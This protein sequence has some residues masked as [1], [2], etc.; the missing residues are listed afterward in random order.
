MSRAVFTIAY[1][2]DALRDGAMD[3]RDLAPALL[4]VGK[5]LD[6]ANLVL[7][8]EES[9][10]SVQMKATSKGSFE[11]SFD[12]IQ[13]FGRQV[14]GLLSGDAVTAALALKEI[15]F[16]SLGV[17]G[18]VIW[19][20]MRLRGRQP[21]KMERLG[22]DQVRLTIDGETLVVPLK[23][24][25]LYQD[26]AVRAAVKEVVQVPL[27]SPGIDAFEVRENR[28]TVLRIDKDELASFEMPD[29]ADEVVVDEVTKAAFSIL[30][31]SFK[32]ENKWRLHDGN[33]A[34]YAL[35]EDQ[36]FLDRV[37]KH[38]ISFTKGDVL[39]CS[40]RIKQKQTRDGLK[41]EYVVE[42]VVDHKRAPRQLP[43]SFDDPGETQGAG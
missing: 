5:L 19:L 29:V 1:D 12:L 34:I 14:I 18:G 16:G 11:I 2:G 39:I 41:T 23:L 42:K 37:N 13:S 38:L 36:E 7:N 4:A 10:I 20:V 26:L 15:V 9:K 6:A 32:E 31:L 24:L 17:G 33:S 40:V 3:V 43:L 35:I 8:G 25:R 22:P 30:S 21:D 27:A 28:Q